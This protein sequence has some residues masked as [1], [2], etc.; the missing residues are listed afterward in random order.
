MQSAP[1]QVAGAAAGMF[2]TLRN[3]GFTLS[4]TLALLSAETSLPPA[5]ATKI[6]L[7]VGHAL[8]ASAAS[9]L[10]HSVDGA[11]RLFVAFYALALVVSLGLLRRVPAPAGPAPAGAAT[12]AP[13]L[14]SRDA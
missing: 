9:A 8:S 14:D 13:R 4:L 5:V 1:A 3:V 12:D 2:Y 6:F 10:V 7:G 11:F